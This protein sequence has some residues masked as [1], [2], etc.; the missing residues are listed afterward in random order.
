MGWG[1]VKPTQ[2]IL[3]MTIN[4][5]SMITMKALLGSGVVDGEGRRVHINNKLRLTLL[6]LKTIL[7]P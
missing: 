6:C 4:Q 3:A 2:W 7:Q 5:S 1:S